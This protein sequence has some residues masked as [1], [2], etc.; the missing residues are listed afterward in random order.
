MKLQIK[1]LIKVLVELLNGFRYA[2]A[3]KV[4]SATVNLVTTLLIAAIVIFSAQE[5][6]AFVMIDLLRLIR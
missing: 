2:F 3:N 6:I 4:S 1:N 5:L